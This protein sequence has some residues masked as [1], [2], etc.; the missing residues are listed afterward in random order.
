MR[1]DGMSP[2]EILRAALGCLAERLADF[3]ASAIYRTK[4]L[5]YAAQDD[6][7]NLVCA[8]EFSRPPED[9]LAWTQSIEARFGRDRT[10]EIPKGP[11][12]LDIDIALFG[13]MVISAP[14]LV[15]PHPQAKERA[16]V[17]IPLLEI[18][19]DS[20]DPISGKKYQIF[21]DR[22]DIT[23]VELIYEN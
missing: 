18:L 23:G 6:F 7:Y 2:P 20:A 12:P 1:R 8:G 9:L 10:R 4:P 17:L 21:L 11:R 15:I 13:D 14:N 3:R 16:F 19:P 22:L 5:Y